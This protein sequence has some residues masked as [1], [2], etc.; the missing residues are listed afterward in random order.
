[1]PYRAALATLACLSP[2]AAQSPLFLPLAGPPGTGALRHVAA[3]QGLRPHVTGATFVTLDRALLDRFVAHG[4]RA[5]RMAVTLGGTSHPLVLDSVTPMWRHRVF[6]GHVAEQGH[7]VLAI[8]ADGVAAAAIEL[9]DSV[10]SLEHTGDGP[11][12]VLYALD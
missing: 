11:V 5:G 6:R 4:V 9:A 2:L 12:H 3:E 10:W 1:M 7:F 8:D